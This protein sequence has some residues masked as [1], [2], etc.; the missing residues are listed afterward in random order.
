MA[1]GQAAGLASRAL[2]RGRGQVVGGRVML[3]LDPGLLPAL[4]AGKAVT[5]VSATNGKSTTT[6]MLVQ[7]LKTQGQ[8]AHNS[9]GA[10]MAPG[11]V[12]ALAASRTAGYAAL[13]VDEAHLPALVRPTRASQVVLMNLS[14]DQ[15]DRGSEVKMLAQRW[16]AMAAGLEP[17]VTLVANADDPMVVWA[18]RQAPK[19]FWVGCG[20]SWTEDSVL[21]PECGQPLRR[22]PGQW[23]CPG[24]GLARPPATWVVDPEAQEL[25]TP[26]GRWPISLALPGQFNLANAAMATAA[27]HGLGVA[28]KAALAACGQ[29]GDVDGRYVTAQVDGHPVRLLLG[30]NPASWTAM[31]ALVSSNSNQLCAALNARGA[32][33]RD[34]SWIWDVPFHQLVSREVWV[35]G[36][37]RYDLAV[38]LEMA[39]LKVRGV[40]QD[41]LDALKDLPPGQ[42]L[43]V[44]ANYTAFQELR[45]RLVG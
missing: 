18:A 33:G 35:T 2:G 31:M 20:L 11:M 38:R 5:L 44:V 24:C 42:G 22:S 41:P 8:V 6:R 4:A 12:T 26:E 39:D 43:D 16:G 34:P 10:N 37:R 23:S 45:A 9:T 25:V 19:V 32:D 7:A 17:A 1:A 13:E 27:A 15:L 3:K 36:E 21:C 30:K 14:R 40:S 29:V 28:V